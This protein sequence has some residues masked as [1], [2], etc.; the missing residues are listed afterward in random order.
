MFLLPALGTLFGIIVCILEFS[1]INLLL[2]I[3]LAMGAVVEAV[4]LI[5]YMTDWIAGNQK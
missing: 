5:D 4:V 1:V 2:T 3:F